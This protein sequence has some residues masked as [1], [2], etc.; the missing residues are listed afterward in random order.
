VGWAVT[1]VEWNKRGYIWKK[2]HGSRKEIPGS[3]EVG[4]KA[5]E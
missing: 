4:S 5:V 3:V 1:F 2:L